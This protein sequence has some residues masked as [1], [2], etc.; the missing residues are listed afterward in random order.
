MKRYILITMVLLATSLT[1]GCKKYLQYTPADTRFLIDMQSI[2]QT[3]ASYLYN[4]QRNAK[5]LGDAPGPWLRDCY[6]STTYLE[7]ADVWSFYNLDTKPSALTEVEK[8]LVD[9]TKLNNPE[10]ASHYAIVGFMNLIIAEGLKT[11]DNE[12]M[13]NYV[14][15]EA[16]VHRGYSLF[17]LLQYYS[18]VDDPALGIPLN[19]SIDANYK[20]LDL[21]RKS[22]KEVFD[23]IISDLTDAEARIN[24][25]SPRASYNIFYNYNVIYRL[26]AQVYHWY[27]S[28]SGS[29]EYWTQAEK[30]ADLAINDQKA[31]AG[32]LPLDLPNLKRLCFTGSV[33]TG[34]I[35]T[36][37][38]PESIFNMNEITASYTNYGYKFDLWNSLY[39]DN[40]LRKRAWFLSANKQTTPIADLT[41]ADINPISNKLAALGPYRKFPAFR[42]SE[43]YL[44]WIE[45]LAHTNLDK[46]KEILKVWQSRR[47]SGDANGYYS[48]GTAQ[49]LVAEVLKERKREFILEGD[50]LWLDMKRSHTSEIRTVQGNQSKLE[51]NDW[52]YQFMIP[53]SE[54]EK[55]PGIKQNPGW[56]DVI[57]IQ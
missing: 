29:T 36:E 30:Y 47:Y 12:E 52:R 35:G 9:R 18:P 19:T 37:G 51:G 48:P 2:K 11:T 43:Q 22:Q 49:E 7:Y 41:P 8:R 13:K 1:Q 15:G 31:A 34:A 6:Y 28:V 45:A 14:V 56:S 53:D 44:I 54:T 32:A 16:L 46:A 20:D 57:I 21:S 42:L 24:K 4:F 27:A 3:L 23:R 40:D 33:V 17:K 39:H 50:I 5:F 25:T 38:Y 26:L 10:W 55:N